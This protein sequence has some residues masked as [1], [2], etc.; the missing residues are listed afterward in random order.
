MAKCEHCPVPADLDC[1]GACGGPMCGLVASG[2]DAAARHVLH[3]AGRP[4]DGEGSAPD[5]P[6]PPQLPGI[7]TRA[8]NF[9][10]AV[11]AHVAAGLPTLPP[12]ATA[13][14]LAVCAPCDQR[15]PGGECAVCGCNLTVKAS[16]REQ[17]CP[18]DKWPKVES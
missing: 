13:A 11:A 1:L 8:A 15:L 16:W 3:H 2:H 18:L 14:R 17:E 12:E 4:C 10:A 9:A 6:P 5:T 7:L